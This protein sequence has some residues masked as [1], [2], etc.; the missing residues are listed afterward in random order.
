MTPAA[1][2]RKR[3]D[4][5]IPV[6]AKMPTWLARDLPGIPTGNS[7]TVSPLRRWPTGRSP[8]RLAR[9]AKSSGVGETTREN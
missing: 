9:K 7:T 4:F 8:M 5:P 1:M 6:V 2:T 3:L